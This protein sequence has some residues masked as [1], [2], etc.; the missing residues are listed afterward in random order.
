MRTR[1][2]KVH[3]ALKHAGYS[4]TTL[5]PGEDATAF[6]KLHRDL[7]VEFTPVGVLEEDIVANI[8]HLTWRKKNLATFRIAELAKGRR[9]EIEYERIPGVPLLTLG[10][11]DPAERQE[12][13]RAAEQQARQELG[14]IYTLIDIGEPATIEGLMKE[15]GIKERLDGLISKCLKQLLMVRGVKS[16]SSASS[17]VATPQISGPRKALRIAHATSAHDGRLKG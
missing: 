6:E 8:A 9:Q 15:L 11:I 16:L 12:A 1:F 10:G 17:S 4:A 14:G 3:P 7:I 13:Y 2:N 5:L